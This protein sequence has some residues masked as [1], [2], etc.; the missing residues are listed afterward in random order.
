[1]AVVSAPTIGRVAPDAR[2]LAVLP[3]Q[4]FS[5]DS[6][7]DYVAD[8][9]TEALISTLSHNPRLRVVSRTSSMPYEQGGKLLREIAEELRV[10]WTSG[11]AAAFA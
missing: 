2:S 9:M 10:R 1:V 6:A 4:N 11:A 3:F 7:A 8:R 5:G